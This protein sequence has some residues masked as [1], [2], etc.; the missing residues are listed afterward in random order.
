ME[1]P[2]KRLKANTSDGRVALF[3]D[4]TQLL[5][6]TKNL[7]KHEPETVQ[8]K[9][10]TYL[11]LRSPRFWSSN[12]ISLIVTL[13]RLEAQLSNLTAAHNEWLDRPVD[14]SSMKTIKL[15]VTSC[16]GIV[17]QIHTLTTRLGLSDAQLYGSMMRHDT[18]NANSREVADVA[19]KHSVVDKENDVVDLATAKELFKQKLKEKV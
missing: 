13:A 14:E 2:Q 11:S 10:I 1:K 5:E 8:D 12:T 6:F 19:L 3:K 16:S 18:H 4:F 9:T 17:T 7:V 15:I